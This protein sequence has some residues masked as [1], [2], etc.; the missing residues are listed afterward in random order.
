[1][2]KLI[3]H[4]I[5]ELES[6]SKYSKHKANVNLKQNLIRFAEKECPVVESNICENQ[7]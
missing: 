6:F 7:I 4:C 1:M 3:S 5:K 2:Y